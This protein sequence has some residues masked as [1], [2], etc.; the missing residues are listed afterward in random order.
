[1]NDTKQKHEEMLYPCVRVRSAKAGGSGT[2][3]YSKPDE[4]GQWRSFVLTCEHVVDDLI[5]V[6]KQWDPVA[7]TDRRMEI[8]NKATVEMFYYEHL[9]RCRGSSGLHRA[10]IVAYD[11]NDDIALLEVERTETPMEFVGW[12]YPQG[13]LNDIHV[14]DPLW[15]VGAAMGHEPIVTEGMLSYMDQEIDGKEYWM[16]TAPSIFGNS[17]GSVFAYSGSRE[18]FEFLGMPA[19]ITVAMYGFSADA[20]THMGFFVPITRIYE[21][22]ERNHYQFIYDEF[23]TYEQCMAERE[24]EQDRERRLILARIGELEQ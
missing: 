16:S 18:R 7:K 12:L 23:K 17:G 1:M 13:E 4:E 19:R 2:V 5:K 22:L 9:S 11:K 24:E 20:I 10:Q 6:E 21:L 3:V 15:C 14:M 8:L